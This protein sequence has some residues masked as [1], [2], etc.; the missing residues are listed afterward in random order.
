MAINRARRTDT[1]DAA[2]KVVDNPDFDK[3]GDEA[4]LPP[5][6]REALAESTTPAALVNPDLPAHRRRAK[7]GTK[8]DAVSF[9]FNA[10]QRRL[11]N[12]AVA[13]LDTTQQEL[14]ETLIWEP[15][16]ERFGHLDEI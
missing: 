7:S 5:S 9:R 4:E 14:L 2:D 12:I 10:A 6:A 15:L 3:F 13:R 11:L 1:Q 16:E 8:V